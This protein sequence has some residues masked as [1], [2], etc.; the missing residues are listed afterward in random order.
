MMMMDEARSFI[1]RQPE[2]MGHLINPFGDTSSR[3]RV[4]QYC[5]DVTRSDR[6]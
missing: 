4:A 1:G 6:E 5:V 2:S 3:K